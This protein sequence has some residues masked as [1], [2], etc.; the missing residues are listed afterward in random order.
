MPLSTAMRNRVR[1]WM[2]GTTMAAAPATWY[3]GLFTSPTGPGS[4]GTEVSGG[5]YARVAVT[6]ATQTATDGDGK[7]RIT[8]ELVFPA[9]TGNQ[10]TVTHIAIHDASSAGIRIA[11]EALPEPKTI[12]TGDVAKFPANSLVVDLSAI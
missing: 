5:G 4:E 8:V 11:W 12:N 2:R 9:A 1:N 6:A 10:G 3:V 7:L